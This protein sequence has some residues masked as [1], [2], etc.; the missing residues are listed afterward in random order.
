ML[1]LKY[2][3]RVIS[4]LVYSNQEEVLYIIYQINRTV[5]YSGAALL[6]SLQNYFKKASPK[7]KN[8]PSEEAIKTIPG[9]LFL[10]R[11]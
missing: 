8:V 2:I 11:V 6:T 9:L 4:S 3:T 1:F 10:L 7:V 5:S